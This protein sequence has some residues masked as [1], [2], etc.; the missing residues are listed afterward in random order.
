MRTRGP[1]K[2][3]NNELALAMELRQEGCTWKIIAYAL[4]VTPGYLCRVVK[5]A[6]REGMK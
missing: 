2:L 6:E 5:Q 4:S 1:H 3:F